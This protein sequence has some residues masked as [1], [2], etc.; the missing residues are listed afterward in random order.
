MCFQFAQFLHPCLK[1]LSYLKFKRDFAK[2]LITLYKQTRESTEQFK[3]TATTIILHHP[4]II[5]L[6]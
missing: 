5:E 2:R 6:N 1:L 4:E 3:T